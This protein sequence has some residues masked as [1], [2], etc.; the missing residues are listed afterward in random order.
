MIC[1]EGSGYFESHWGKRLVWTHFH[2]RVIAQKVSVGIFIQ[3]F[4]LPHLYHYN[5]ACMLRYVADEY[6][7]SNAEDPETERRVEA[8]F[9]S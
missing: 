6:W 7:L 5:Y 3:Y 4:N 2:T 8:S 1:S 9:F